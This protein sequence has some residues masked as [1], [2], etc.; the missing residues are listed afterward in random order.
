[1]RE[2]QKRGSQSLAFAVVSEEILE[3]I[4]VGSVE[5][6]RCA[7]IPS[8][9]VTFPDSIWLEGSGG[10]VELRFRCEFNQLLLKYSSVPRV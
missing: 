5:F 10:R 8:R 6:S 3:V 4:F 2:E 1:M 9:V 7:T